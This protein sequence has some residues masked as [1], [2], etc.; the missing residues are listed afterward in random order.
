[1]GFFMEFLYASINRIKNRRFIQG[2]V[3]DSKSLL[4]QLRIA[5]PGIMHAIG[6]K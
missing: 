4:L 3:S 5:V 2:V 1:M 6:D